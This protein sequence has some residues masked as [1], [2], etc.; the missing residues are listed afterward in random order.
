MLRFAINPR[1]TDLPNCSA[2]LHGLPRDYS[3]SN[4][5]TTLSI[6]TVLRGS[7]TYQTPDG[8][9]LVTPENF[10][11]LNQGQEYSM[12]VDAASHTE[13]FCPFFQPE[14]VPAGG[15]YERLYPMTG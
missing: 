8:R 3:V 4:Y 13:T 15:F 5:K 9:Y 12:E 1:W 11:I 2:V 7:A 6:K 10:L 14:F